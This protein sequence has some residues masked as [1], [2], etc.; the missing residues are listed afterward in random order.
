MVADGVVFPTNPATKTQVAG[1]TYGGFR[2]QDCPQGAPHSAHKEGL[3]VDR[4][5]PSGAIDSW[6]LKNQYALGSCGVYIEHPSTT[7]GWSHWSIRPP[8]SGHHVFY[9]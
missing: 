9:P 4:Y 6:L 2:P 1:E 3:A 8:A 7:K 5:D